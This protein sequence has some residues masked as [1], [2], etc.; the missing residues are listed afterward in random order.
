MQLCNHGCISTST[1][2]N[3][4]NYNK[5][6]E[7]QIK[8]PQDYPTLLWTMYLRKEAHFR[9]HSIKQLKFNRATSITPVP[10]SQHIAYVYIACNTKVQLAKFYL[11][12][13]FSN[14]I[15]TFFKYINPGHFVTRSNCWEKSISGILLTDY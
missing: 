11:K 4:T 8:V 2:I 3:V 10:T 12:Y 6:I 9:L 15:S 7:P 14:S 1:N 5:Q 13:A